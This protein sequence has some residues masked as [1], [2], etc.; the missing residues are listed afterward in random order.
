M[1]GCSRI[2]VREGVVIRG[3]EMVD[4]LVVVGVCIEIGY[5]W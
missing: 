2:S 5:W 1:V 4:V 3:K